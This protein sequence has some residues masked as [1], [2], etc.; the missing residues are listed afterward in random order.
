MVA[1]V[2]APAGWAPRQILLTRLERELGYRVT[3]V[4][5]GEI[6]KLYLSDVSA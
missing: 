5:A 4:G 2:E 6:W 3:M 1:Y